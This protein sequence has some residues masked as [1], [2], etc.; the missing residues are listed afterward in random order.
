MTRHSTLGG[1]A[2]DRIA[3]LAIVLASYLMIVLDISIVITGLPE[4]KQDLGFSAVGLSWV[5]NAYTLCF[6]GFLLLAAR[7][8]DIFGRRRMFIAGLVLFTASSFVIGFAPTAGW[9]IAAR[10]VQGIGAAILAPSVLALIA[11]N[12]REGPERTQALAYYSMVAGVGSSLGLVLGGVFAGWLSWRVGFF[13]NVPLGIVL[14]LAAR[15][16]L[17]EPETRPGAFDIPGAIASTLGMGALVFGLV[18]AAEAG[19]TDPTARSTLTAA[20]LLLVAFVA[21]EAR[22][23]APM[24]PLHLFADRRR[25]AA[26]LAR[27][28]FLGAMVGFLFFATQLMQIALD[29][30]PFQAGLG[31]LPMTIPTFIAA[32]G[33]PAAT[34]R[35]GNGGVIA[36]ALALGAAG[37]AWLAQAHA[38]SSFVLGI[39][40]PMILVGL[41]NGLALGPLTVAGVAGVRPE[42]AGAASGV[43]NVAHQMGGT[44]GLAF[45]VL[46]F[47]SASPAGSLTAEMFVQRI[48][49]ALFAASGLLAAGFVLAVCLIMPPRRAVTQSGASHCLAD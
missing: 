43:V 49:V 6:G 14:I 13:V 36:L 9:L 40:L 32:L 27:A 26:Y 42:D 28:L 10:A 16:K 21:I 34:R 33:V 25:S 19:W 2:R 45:L 29:Y 11:A 1:I 7:A 20:V 31:F 39:A 24:M 17:P 15:A 22:S 12:F 46:V 18:R 47:A 3:M 8:G 44:L 38:D 35:F 4:I 41:G 30:T 23:R 37:L 5:Q 48:D